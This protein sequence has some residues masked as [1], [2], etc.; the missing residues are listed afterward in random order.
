VNN[1]GPMGLA[2]LEIRITV[3]EFASTQRRIRRLHSLVERT[4]Q[5]LAALEGL[6]LQKVARVPTPLRSELVGLVDDL[7]FEFLSPIRLRPKP[8]ALIDLVF[9]IQKDLFGMIRGR[10]LEDDS[11]VAA[12]GEL[13]Q[14]E[15]CGLP[16]F[17]QAPSPRGPVSLR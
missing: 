8:T 14:D 5:L 4:D 1:I 17:P 10:A 2:C 12:K 16:S 7:P 13:M 9:D 15:T 6:N 11:E 3:D